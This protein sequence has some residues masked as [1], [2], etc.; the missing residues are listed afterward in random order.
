MPYKR[1]ASPARK[2]ETSRS[3]RSPR[4]RTYK[5][6]SVTLRRSRSRERRSAS[7]PRSRKRSTS[8]ERYIRERR[9]IENEPTD[10][11]GIPKHVADAALKK[12]IE[13]NPMFT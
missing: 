6:K 3:P 12:Y 7:E 11:H 10:Y 2:S 4:R 13:E 9:K 5:R 1:R 8:L